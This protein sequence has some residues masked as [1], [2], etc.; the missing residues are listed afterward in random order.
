MSQR[1]WLLT[2][3]SGLY[4]RIWSTFLGSF[5]L[6]NRHPAYVGVRGLSSVASL[7]AEDLFVKPHGH[8]Q[9]QKDEI[10]GRKEEYLCVLCFLCKQY[11]RVYNNTSIV[12]S[13]PVM[14]TPSAATL[15]T[16]S[17]SVHRL[18]GLFSTFLS[19]AF[20]RHFS[21]HSQFFLSLNSKC[22]RHRPALLCSAFV[23]ILFN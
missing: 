21:H 19:L 4:G 1:L 16:W 22:S 3:P 13:L 8:L 14:L 10:C 20:S 18:L 9:P 17:H 5:F 6:L 11:L 2:D 12:Q 7:A 15:C 23:F